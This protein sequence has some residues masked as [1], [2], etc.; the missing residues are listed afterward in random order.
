MSGEPWLS[1]V[2]PSHNGERWLGEAM[3]SVADQNEVGIE[4][5]IVDSSATDTSLRVATN[6][7][8]LLDLQI[9]RR[10]DFV[11]WTAKTN[12]AVQQARAPWISML[13]QDDLWLP[14]RA[15]AIRQWISAQPD[16]IMHV[17]PAHIIDER[18]K[19]LG[20]W[21]CPLPA[22]GA[23]VP[24]QALTERLL[25]QN[26]IAIPTP[27]IRRDALLASGGL[28]EALWY[29]ADW[30]LY[31]K[32]SRA[33][34]VCYH[35]EVLAC[36]R[37]HKGSLTISG[38]RSIA[39]FRQQL[40]TV[41]DRYAAG[42]AGA[43]SRRAL[44]LATASIA[45]NVGLAAAKLGR[46]AELLKALILLLRLGPSGLAKYLYCSRIFE[47]VLPRLRARFAGGL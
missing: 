19:R 44:R 33:G 31:L 40:E 43:D 11:A 42:M 23:P 2:I 21:R 5:V 17:H 20:T 7:A 41:R 14:G 3:Q 29:T 6:F 32:L 39:D 27:V 18:G 28:D 26:F 34:A 9:C 35:P 47:R 4:V 37:I 22:T 8:P 25:V 16:I 24:A 13:H 12:F 36:F 38:S 46:R 45:V 10:L 15:A 1:V 30:D